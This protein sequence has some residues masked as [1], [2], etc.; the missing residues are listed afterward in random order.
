MKSQIPEI[1]AS[2]INLE[3]S[4][5]DFVKI[6]KENGCLLLKNCFT[7]TEDQVKETKEFIE[8]AGDKTYKFGIA[9][10]TGSAQEAYSGLSFLKDI[11]EKD[12]MK[13]LAWKY[14]PGSSLIDVFITHEFKQS[15]ELA[16]NGHLHFDKLNTFKFMFYMTDCD[17]SSGAFS[18]TPESHVLGAYLREQSW[19]DAG[20]P[21]PGGG[22][23]ESVKNKIDQD[24]SHLER[25][26]HPI[27]A[28]AGSIIIF[29]TDLFHKGGIVESGK[30]RVLVRTHYSIGRGDACK[31]MTPWKRKMWEEKQNV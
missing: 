26:V 8:S 11:I 27:E 31:K 7:I 15:N 22:R 25:N 17:K 24:F 19:I 12:W 13:S 1:D 10:K 21:T 6:I 18:V 2:K 3:D 29:D 23:Y 28:P 9:Y 4:V 30:E 5:D 16:A 14:W 20:F